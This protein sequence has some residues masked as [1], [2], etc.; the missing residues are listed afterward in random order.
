MRAVFELISFL[1]ILK[2]IYL[3]RLF[4]ILIGLKTSKLILYEMERPE[5]PLAREPDFDLEI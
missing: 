1:Q 4:M 2:E 5:L 3:I